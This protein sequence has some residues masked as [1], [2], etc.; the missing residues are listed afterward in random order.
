MFDQFKPFELV[1]LGDKNFLPSRFEIWNNGVKVKEGK[2]ECMVMIFSDMISY[3]NFVT[4]ENND[5]KENLIPEFSFDTCYTLQDRILI[6]TLP[7]VNN[8]EDNEVFYGLWVTTQHT[9]AEKKFETNEPYLGSLYYLNDELNKVTFHIG[10]P[11]NLIE[12]Y[13]D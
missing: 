2:T 12:F 9:R 6:S 3:K 11:Q 5:I 8:L 4:I 10:S 13:C 1:N 7:T